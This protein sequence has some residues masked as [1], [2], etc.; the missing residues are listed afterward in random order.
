VTP[1]PGSWRDAGA[2]M[3]PLARVTGAASRARLTLLRGPSTDQGTPG[4]LLRPDGSRIAYSLEL[5]WRGNRRCRSSVPP[6]LPPAGEYLCRMRRSPKFGPVYEVLGVPG[7]SNILIHA[8]NVA[9]DVEKGFATDLLGCIALGTYL[10]TKEGQLAVLVSR[11]AV[12]AF[13]REMGG[14]DFLLEIRPWTLVS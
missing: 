8:A 2:S 11:P 12:S 10:G 5:P 6:G 14:D 13:Q 7:R 4:A 9:G 1:A 3:A